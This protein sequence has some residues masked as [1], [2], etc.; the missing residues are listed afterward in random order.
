MAEM[1]ANAIPG[2]WGYV[3]I[4]FVLSARGPVVIEVTPRLSDLYLALRETRHVNLVELSLDLLRRATPRTA[5]V[6]IIPWLTTI[7]PLGF[8]AGT[9][10]FAMLN[11]VDLAPARQLF[12]WS[13]LVGATANLAVLAAPDFATALACRFLSGVRVMALDCPHDSRVFL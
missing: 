12:A 9:A 8:V 13:A 10:L 3:S 4:H 11:V 7:V 2:L 6:P 1:V 5:P